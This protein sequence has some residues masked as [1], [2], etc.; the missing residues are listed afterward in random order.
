MP[1]PSRADYPGWSC[2]LEALERC[3]ARFAT[4][5]GIGFFGAGLL[6][7]HLHDKDDRLAG[8]RVTCRSMVRLYG[9][10]LA[11]CDLAPLRWKAAGFSALTIW[12]RR[13]PGTSAIN[14]RL[15]SIVLSGTDGLSRD[16]Q[17]RANRAHLPL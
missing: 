13:L 8:R 15:P 11:V 10:V 9:D 4:D 5:G 7:D 17:R 3:D 12:P 1:N 6:I 16:Y 14:Y 2:D